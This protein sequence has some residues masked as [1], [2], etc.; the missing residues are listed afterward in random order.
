MTSLPERTNKASILAR[1]A[2]AFS[3]LMV[4]VG[5]AISALLIMGVLNAMRNA[6]A[7]GIGAVAIGLAEASLPTVVALYLAIF[8]MAIGV[9]VMIIRA[10]TNPTTASPSA[11]FFAIILLLSFLPLGLAWKAN[12]LLIGT[13]MARGNVSIVAPTIQLFS[14]ITV[15]TSLL[16]SLI[17]IT[18]VLIPLPSF[19]RT[20]RTW[21][22]I[23]M[24]VMIEIVLIGLVIGFQMHMTWLRGVGLRESF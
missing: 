2:P 7:A 6:E 20:R 4:M 10:A 19:L 8:V 22:P 11:L 1:I 17:V 18:A 16:F 5:A 21:P 23:V 13:L 12:S 3:S 15:V 9:I 14:N 24:L